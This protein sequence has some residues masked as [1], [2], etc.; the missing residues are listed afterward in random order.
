[1]G[2]SARD[3]NITK[4]CGYFIEKWDHKYW[5]ITVSI[6]LVLQAPSLSYF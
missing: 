5:A 2:K 3:E 1:M 6:V 4:L